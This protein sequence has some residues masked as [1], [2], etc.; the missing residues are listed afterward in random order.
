MT[1]PSTKFEN[2][3]RVVGASFVMDFLFVLKH[4]ALR[5]DPSAWRVLRSIGRLIRMCAVAS[6]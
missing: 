6:H 3:C 1:R 4:E 5:A 2:V